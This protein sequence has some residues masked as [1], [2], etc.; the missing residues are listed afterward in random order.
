VRRED[1][2]ELLH[3]A[4]ATLAVYGFITIFEESFEIDSAVITMVFKYRH[5]SV[6]PR[7]VDLR[8]HPF[9]NVTENGR[10]PHT[11]RV[12]KDSPHLRVHFPRLDEAA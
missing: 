7:R 5:T 9:V 6:S 3:I 4:A 12:V 2:H 11:I 1:A 10:Y 8:G